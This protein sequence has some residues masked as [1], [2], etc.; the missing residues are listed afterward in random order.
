ML[1]SV[2]REML[3]SSVRMGLYDPLKAM[4]PG[5]SSSLFNK[6][7]AGGISGTIG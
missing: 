3:Y 1:A 6:I 7:L 5:D 2:T 4:L